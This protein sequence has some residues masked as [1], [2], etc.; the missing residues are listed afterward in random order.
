MARLSHTDGSN[1]PDFYLSQ[2][3]GLCVKTGSK[4]IYL[5]GQVNGIYFMVDLVDMVN[6]SLITSGPAG[7]ISVQS[8][9]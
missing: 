6:C 4:N 1:H 7:F 5:F 8:S 2:K 3:L 9:Y